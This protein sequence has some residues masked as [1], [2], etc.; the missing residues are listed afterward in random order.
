MPLR[1]NP[2]SALLWS[3]L[4]AQLAVALQQ[5]PYNAYPASASSDD[6]ADGGPAVER[7][8]VAADSLHTPLSGQRGFR[9]TH[10]DDATDQKTPRASQLNERA[11]AT[12]SP[13]GD[14]QPPAVRAPPAPR[15]SA[16][17]AGLSSRQ[18]ARSLQD[19]Q[20]EDIMLLATVD[21]KIH[22]RDRRTGAA[23]W[24]LE[25]D[26]PMVETTYHPR[27]ITPLDADPGLEQQDDPLWIVEPSQDGSI[28]VFLPGSAIGMQ[29]LDYT[30]KQ[31]VELTPYDSQTQPSVTYTADKKT[32]LYTVDASTGNILRSFSSMGT[33]SNN[34]QSCRRVN[35]LETLEEDECE[36]IGT[37]TLGRTE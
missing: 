14:S 11:L 16:A 31:L 30:V 10:V 20:V 1:S 12:L 4:L 34:D 32:T 33:F 29:K 26:R 8:W 23:R 24:Q 13:A 19:W 28:Y 7:R 17:S 15:S 6:L 37:I 27:N 36:P 18:P 21:G 2:K 35:P 25:T 9:D 3:L 22:A 5:Q